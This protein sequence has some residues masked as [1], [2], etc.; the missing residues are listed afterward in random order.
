M[1]RKSNFGKLFHLWEDIL[2][3]K[4]YV[5]KN[6]PVNN[7]I[8][9]VLLLALVISQSSLAQNWEG[10]RKTGFWERWAINV[11][12]GYTSYYGELS[13]YDTEFSGKIMHESGPAYGAIIS[14]YLNNIVGVSGQILVGKLKGNKGDMSFKTELLEYNLQLRINF[15]NLFNNSKNHKIGVLGFAGIGQ[16][17]FTTTIDKNVEGQI[18]STTSAARVPEFVIFAGGGVH[19]ILGDNYSISAGLSLRQSQ[20]D[21]LDGI[22][23]N[24]DTDYYTYLN[25]GLTYYIPTFIKGPLR[26]KARIACS[27]FKF[28]H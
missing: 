20:N 17:L 18:T 23:K 4:V 12:G 26:N 5:S 14:K 24:N 21:K 7:K 9:P 11:N 2:M 8:I 15:V 16:F 22:K 25:F 3:N 27:N 19:Y 10:M 6:W 28:G 1:K 13:L